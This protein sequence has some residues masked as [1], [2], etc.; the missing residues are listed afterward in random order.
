MK[1]ERCGQRKALVLTVTSHLLVT[2]HLVT[3]ITFVRKLTW[4]YRPN[5]GAACAVKWW[6]VERQIGLVAVECVVDFA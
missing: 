2:R 3:L 4:S 5:C 6:W 1:V